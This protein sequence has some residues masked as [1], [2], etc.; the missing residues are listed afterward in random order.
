MINN[1]QTR[2]EGVNQININV[3]NILDIESLKELTKAIADIEQECNCT[4]T[5]D[6]DLG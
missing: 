6:V 4:C 3:M 2:K 1:H 5:L